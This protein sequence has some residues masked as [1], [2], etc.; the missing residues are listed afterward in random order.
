MTWSTLYLVNFLVLANKKLHWW[1]TC[2]GFAIVTFFHEYV[3]KLFA[4][5]FNGGQEP[6]EPITF[7]TLWSLSLGQNPKVKTK[8]KLSPSHVGSSIIF[9]I[10]VFQTCIFKRSHMLTPNKL[11]LKQTNHCL[12]H[13]I[14]VIL[15]TIFSWH[16]NFVIPISKGGCRL[17]LSRA[18]AQG[19]PSLVFF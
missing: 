1:W 14:V 8:K 9:L 17:G 3:L 6:G 2:P 12:N 16:E 4:S 7:T 10:E 18:V 11:L 5:T 13:Y 15:Q 19:N